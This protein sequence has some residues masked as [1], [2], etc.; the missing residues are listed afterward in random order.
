MFTI[1]FI[2]YYFVHIAKLNNILFLHCWP[3]N[4]LFQLAH[5]AH[6][7]GIFNQFLDLNA[8]F[9]QAEHLQAHLVNHEIIK[10]GI[11]FDI[12]CDQSKEVLKMANTLSLFND[13]YHWLII[14]RNFDLK[15]LRERFAEAQL[16]V[17][18]ELTYVEP[19]A[20][21]T[22]FILYDLYNK[23]KHLG[24][25]LNITI[26]QQIVCNERGCHVKRYL[27]DLH[28][29]LR[30][31]N[32]RYFTG[33]TLRVNA[34][35]TAMPVDSPEEQ[36]KE[37]LSSLDDI[38][39]DSYA[40]LG[41]QTHQV[42]KDLLDC[43]FSF[44]FRDR[45]TDSELTG[46]LIGDLING[47]VDMTTTAF[48]YTLGRTKYFRPLTWH[49]SFRSVC[50]FRNPRS[51]GAELR[52]TEFLE[53]FSWTVWLMFSALLLFTGFLL[54]LTFLLE[55]R[56]SRASSMETS[57]L[58]SCLL[59]FGAA[60]IQ[61]AWLL[62][63]STGGRMVFYAIMLTCFLMYNYYTSIVVSTL[64]GAPPKSNIRT[65]QQLADSNLEV[66]VEPT[67]YT[68][69]YVE[70][71][72]FPDIRSLYLNKILNKDPKRIWLPSEQGVLMVRNHPGFVFI[73]ESASAY[74]FV[75]KHYLPH[76]ICELNEILLRDETSAN[77][78]ILKTSNF[79]ELFKLCQLRLLETGVH[80][81]HFR[82]WVRNKLHCYQSN[83]T[84]V[85]GLESAGPL[86][87][88]LLMAYIIC[89]FVLGLEILWHKRQ[90]R[91]GRN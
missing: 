46:G 84:V 36:I 21:F 83:V 32:R 73:A 12:N 49:S 60:C 43:N 33:I 63:R 79:A 1:Q 6:N 27:S 39:K 86:F 67:I 41:Y 65:I 82:Y 62:P 91:K 3:A 85:V 80:F 23:A 88:L 68:K 78:I 57:L 37:F 71:A 45:W 48:L 61:G 55:R 14:D 11:Y 42:F 28:L 52:V 26:D 75:R 87:L 19:Q 10:L 5:L 53:P 38:Y 74:V 69:V 50:M 24:S 22:S 30:L 44:T 8:T 51:A 56:L 54:W 9:S 47:S 17:N 2:I 7:S 35:I 66:A 89:L 59:S 72:E 64:L 40:R 29:R 25:K 81:K 31:Q 90:L 70:T 16:Y 18:S 15:Q 20:N 34:A 4:S 13:H 77:T 58:T 76:E